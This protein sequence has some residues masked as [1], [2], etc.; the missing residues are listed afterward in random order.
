MKQW[1]ILLGIGLI[2]LL[3][4]RERDHWM[5]RQA[6]PAST[7]AWTPRTPPA[8]ESPN[9]IPRVEGQLT[10]ESAEKSEFANLVMQSQR[11]AIAKY[12]ALRNVNSE[13]NIRFNFRCKLLLDE[14][15]PR[16][17]DPNW[18]VQLA[19]ECAR[20]SNVRPAP[21][22]APVP[23]GT[24]PMSPTGTA[25][26][27]SLRLSQSGSVP[28]QTLTFHPMSAGESPAFSADAA[29]APALRRAGALPFV[30]LDAVSQNSGN[31]YHYN[32][33]SDYGSYDISFRQSVGVAINARNMSRSPAELNLRC[34]FFARQNDSN[35]RFVFAASGQELDLTPGQS[36]SLVVD[37]PMVQGRTVNFAILGQTYL[38]GS[39]YEG[40]LVQ[41]LDRNGNRLLR[42][43]GSTSYLEDLTLK[44][45]FATLIDAY[46]TKLR[47]Q[48][49]SMTFPETATH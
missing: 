25:P 20:D 17:Q 7:S 16:L 34:I 41:L 46:H 21:P 40:W 42:Q 15:N 5:S 28:A 36:A 45:D 2:A 9:F 49:G 13:I 18:P 1:L 30:T 3:A 24:K 38:S 23:P 26:A 47:A 11:A 12:P 14:H 44:T 27:P 31:N 37:S 22:P 19:D 6:L 29:T 39:R 10:L 32:W 33:I 4:V 48:G 8:K 35:V 43:T